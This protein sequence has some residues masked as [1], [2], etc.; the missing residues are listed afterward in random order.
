MHCDG[1]NKLIRNEI[2]DTYTLNAVAEVNGDKCVTVRLCCHF[3]NL[4]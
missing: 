3:H 2:G 1:P 4:R